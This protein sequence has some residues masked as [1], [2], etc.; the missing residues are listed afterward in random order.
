[1]LFNKSGFKVFNEF[2]LESTLNKQMGT[3]RSDLQITDVDE[4]NKTEVVDTLISKYKVKPL[5]F[6][7]DEIEVSTKEELIPSE[8]FP[9]SGF[10]L[11]PG[12]EYPKDIY[13][14]YLPFTGEEILLHCVAS[15]RILWTEEVAVEGSTVIFQVIN[16]RNSE[17]ELFMERN[18]ILDYL[19]AQTNHV[20][21]Q[22]EKFNE[23]IELFIRQELVVIDQKKSER[24]ILVT[25]LG[26][27][28]M[29]IESDRQDESHAGK[30]LKLNAKTGKQ[31]DVFI[32]H[33]SED[34]EYVGALANR[35]KEEGF[36]VWYDTFE[37]SWGDDLRPALDN[38]LK[39][40]KFGL[41][42]LSFS[43]LRRK[44][45]T[46]F[47]LNGLFA[48]EKNQGKTVLPIWHGISRDD[49]VE[50]SL[51]LADRIAMNSN[52]I[53]GIISELHRLLN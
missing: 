5:I 18:R 38:G 37:I 43:F 30:A 13:T 2:D 20:N 3:L 1:M 44:T 40:S 27:P 21:S 10:F 51:T 33:A 9:S 6:N 42:V 41:V 7:R 19:A 32:S 23:S 11:R 46:E 36:D 47:E 34:K 8:I 14:F 52:N 50:Y 4:K 45:W 16:F 48:K 29:A 17:D 12:E 35:L 39:N 49:V 28:R 22:V 26:K 24:N 15:T 53:N 31:F 25:K